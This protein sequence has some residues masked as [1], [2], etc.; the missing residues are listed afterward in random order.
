MQCDHTI[1]YW[2]AFNA[3][4]CAP[5]AVCKHTTQYTWHCVTIIF[6]FRQSSA[7]SA[8]EMSCVLSLGG[9]MIQGNNDDVKERVG[10]P[11]YLGVCRQDCNISQSLHVHLSTIVL[12]RIV[13]LLNNSLDVG[14]CVSKTLLIFPNC[15]FWGVWS[16]RFYT[17]TYLSDRLNV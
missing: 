6:A 9:C 15:Q 10:V 2:H 11:E 17:D 3:Q 1:H 14:L 5:C 13:V 4:W 7:A 8:P 12:S 16:G